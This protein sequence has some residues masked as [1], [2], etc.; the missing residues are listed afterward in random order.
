MKT[1]CIKYYYAMDSANPNL[2]RI[3]ISLKPRQFHWSLF[4]ST[5]LTIHMYLNPIASLL[6]LV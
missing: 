2:L 5:S 6:Q 4:Y 1:V 3:S